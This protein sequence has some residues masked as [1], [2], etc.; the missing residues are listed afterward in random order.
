MTVGIL[1]G[2]QLGRM[3]ALAGYPLGVRFRVLDTYPDAPAGEMAELVVGESFDDREAL[4]RF[5]TGLNFVTYEFENVPV[6]AARFLADRVPVYPPPEALEASQDR[7]TEK[8]FLR[9]LGVDT[10]EFGPVE[11]LEALQA[12]LRTLGSPAVLKTRRLGYDGKGQ[13]ILRQEADAQIAW[14][15]LQGQSLIL[16]AFVPF[17]REVSLLSVRG[18]DGTTA[19]YPLVENYHR[20]GILRRSIA[21][22]PSTTPALQAQAEDFGRRVLE[23]LDYVG[24]LAIEF[25]QIED[26][27][28]ANEMAPRVHNSG[29]WTIEGAETSQFENHLRAV[30]G[31]PLGAT[32][33]R[34][35][36]VMLNLIGGFPERAAMLA[37]PNAHVH[38][39]AKEPRPGR[40][41]GHITLRGDDEHDVRRSAGAL[42]DSLGLL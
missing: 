2:G 28:L 23:A 30:L 6:D 16:E 19:F 41:V 36:S 26:R 31:L 12:A 20:D 37:V 14:E 42:A 3:L 22:A 13:H 5:A 33:P 29:H 4:A 9:E 32:T 17:D 7:L 18:R 11:S 21:P 24:V 38:L 10:P 1:G 8:T 39:Y 27:L 25:F 15:A 40:K 35:H 34:G